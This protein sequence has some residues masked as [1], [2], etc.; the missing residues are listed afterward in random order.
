[1]KAVLLGTFEHNTPEW[2][3]L[4]ANGLGGSEVASV[5]GLSPWVS[6][7]AL[8][9]RKRGHLAPQESSPSMDWGHRLEPVVCDAFAERH[10][11]FWLISAGTMRH[12]ERGWQIA[13][14]DKMLGLDGPGLDDATAVLEVKTA[15]AH[16]APQWGPDGTDEVPPYYR[17]QAM[18]YLDA[19]EL[20]TTHMAVLIGGNDYR[21]Y[22]IEYVRDEAEWLR[23][24]G[25]LFW[26]SVLDDNPPPIDGSD[27]TYQAIRALHPDLQGPLEVEIDPILFEQ[28]IT[29]A[30]EAKRQGEAA[31]QAKNL[32]AQQM[33]TAR[34]GTVFGERVVIRQSNKG[35]LPY[36]KLIP[37]KKESA[38]A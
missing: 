14:T 8:W 18:W 10:P 37:Q 36:P 22:V 13:S 6:K 28:W 29:A 30:D 16:D 11:E 5:V 7:F 19:T 23:E 1:M 38:N 4:R 17:C 26:Q 35:N 24:E 20:P 34:Y 25:R 31:S 12:R 33:G 27:S 15:D 32:V 9:H 21:E 2:H 3:G